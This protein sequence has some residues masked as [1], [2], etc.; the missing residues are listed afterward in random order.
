MVDFDAARKFVP[1][2]IYKMVHQDNLK[3]LSEKQVFS[4][5]FSKCTL[6]LLQ[7]CAMQDPAAGDIAHDQAR[8]EL[9]FKLL[10]RIVFDLL[11]NSSSNSALKDMTDL[12]LM[13]LSK[14]DAAV[15][16]LFQHRVFAPKESL[17]KDEKNFFEML[18]THQDKDARDMAATTLCFALNRLLQMG[19]EQHLQWVDDAVTQVLDLM[20]TECQKHWM[21]LDTYLKFIYDLA[22]SHI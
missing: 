7:L 19:G 16:Y 9:V 4:D 14:S 5:A 17:G 22:K 20:P 13:M 11:V 3:F 8:F 18:A 6:E 21:R 1:N 10:D 12:L 15:E 2:S